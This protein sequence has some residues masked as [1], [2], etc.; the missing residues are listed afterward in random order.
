MSQSTYL[1]FIFHPAVKPSSSV[2]TSLD[3]IREFVPE[4]IYII[5]GEFSVSTF[6]DETFQPLRNIVNSYEIVWKQPI[7][8]GV[9]RP[10]IYTQNISKK[11]KS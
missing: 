4:K 10:C 7:L 3:V 9:I 1:C 11:E 2:A 6:D 8:M 5:L